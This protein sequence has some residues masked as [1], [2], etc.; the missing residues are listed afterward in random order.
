MRTT[1]NLDSE[2]LARAQDLTGLADR[3]DLLQEALRALI[4]REAA[5]RLMRLA[6]SMP[7]AHDVPR[8]RA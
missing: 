7:E 5:R 8:R 1:V 2:L 3:T 4:A 6:G